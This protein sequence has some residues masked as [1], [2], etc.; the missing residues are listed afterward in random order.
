MGYH[1]LLG[2]GQRKIQGN[3][4]QSTGIFFN[5]QGSLHLLNS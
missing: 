5:A 2:V 1:D 4:Y 3:Q